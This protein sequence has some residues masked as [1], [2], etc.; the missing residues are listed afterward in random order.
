ML[1]TVQELGKW[2]GIK[3]GNEYIKESKFA[4]GLPKFEVGGTY[5]IEIKESVSKTD[6]KIYKNIV[7]ARAVNAEAPSVPKAPVENTPAKAPA[8]KESK[9]KAVAW[10]RELSDY[11][12]LKDQ[13]IGVA[14]LVQ[15]L[16]Q[17]T[18]YMPQI[19]LLDPAKVDDFVVEKARFLLKT[20]K[21]LSEGK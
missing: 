21:E 1:I 16:L 11:E 3:V 12:L 10:G 15:A 17:S 5:D 13:R 20:V 2:G 6:G 7:A 19:E 4:K 18:I 8:K 9:G 14:G